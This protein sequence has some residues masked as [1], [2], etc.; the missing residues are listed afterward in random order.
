M[1]GLRIFRMEPSFGA[2]DAVLAA[3]AWRRGCALTSADRSFRSVDGLIC[4]D[5]SAPTF[6][7]QAST[8][9]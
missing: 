5:L 8:V 2:F 4:L 7:A 1:E 9:P 6:L 3:T